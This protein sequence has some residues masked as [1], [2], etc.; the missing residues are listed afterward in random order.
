MF[1]ST[2]VL[3]M[4]AQSV[5]P[6]RPDDSHAVYL[7]PGSFGAAADGEADDTTAIQAA[8]DRQTRSA[9]CV[10]CFESLWPNLGS[11]VGSNWVVRYEG[12]IDLLAQRRGA[13]DQLWIDQ[14]RP[15]TH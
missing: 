10:P 5:F 6:M 1:V 4:T 14:L 13:H 8:I 12:K 9:S 3:P 15:G 7:E 11:S 2:A